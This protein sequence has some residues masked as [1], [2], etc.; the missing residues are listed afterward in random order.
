MECTR[1]NGEK[2][3]VFFENTADVAVNMTGTKKVYI[4]V[5]QAKIDNGSTNNEDGTGV[6]SIQTGASWPTD[7]FIPLYDVVSGTV[8]DAREDIN[9]KDAI[10]KRGIL[11]PKMT[12]VTKTGDYTFDGSEA[13]NTVFETNNTGGVATYTIDLSLFDTSKGLWQFT[14]EKKS[15]NAHT[16]VLNFGAGTMD[17][18]STYTITSQNER[19]TFVVVNSTTA[20]VVATANK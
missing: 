15:S 7:N 3:M 5:D 1:A 4:L 2:I 11:L 13:N 12:V 10:E 14:V 6:A 9:I 8:T 18:A 16:V 17:G 20:K 19:V